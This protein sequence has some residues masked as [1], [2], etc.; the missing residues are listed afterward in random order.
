MGMGR[1][2]HSELRLLLPSLP[3]LPLPDSTHS[4]DSHPDSEAVIVYLHIS[5]ND[6]VQ[7][8]DLTG[9]AK[10]ADIEV[11]AAG[12]TQLCRK[13][14]GRGSTVHRIWAEKQYDGGDH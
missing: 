2:G 7:L 10:S 4:S 11:S 13:Q 14:L 8:F 12:S 6:S 5:F 3:P 9:A 1:V